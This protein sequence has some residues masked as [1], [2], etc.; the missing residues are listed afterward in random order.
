MILLTPP[1]VGYESWLSSRDN[2]HSRRIFVWFIFKKWQFNGE[3]AAQAE[4]ADV[5]AGLCDFVAVSQWPLRHQKWWRAHVRRGGERAV[6]SGLG[7]FGDNR[8]SVE[9]HILFYLY[10]RRPQKE[11]QIHITCVCIFLYNLGRCTLN[12]E[13]KY[14][15]RCPYQ[16]KTGGTKAAARYLF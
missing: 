1:A 12:R 2:H 4:N 13:Y 15:S 6:K 10:C 5:S 7:F 3:F 8:D 9:S 16:W 11:Y 14:F